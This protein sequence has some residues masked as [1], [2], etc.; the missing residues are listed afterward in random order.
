MVSA[1]ANQKEH[2]F[3]TVHEEEGTE[4]VLKFLTQRRDTRNQL[5][6]NLVLAS[7]TLSDLDNISAA[8]KDSESRRL[9]PALDAEA[10]CH[11]LENLPV[12]LPVSPAGVTSP[13]VLTKAALTFLEPKLEI[14]DAGS[15]KQP[16]VMHRRINDEVAKYPTQSDLGRA[17][18]RKLVTDLFEQG[19]NDSRN[20][21][22]LELIAECVP[23]GTTSAALVLAL[24][25]L[26]SDSSIRMPPEKLASYCSSS[27]LGAKSQKISFI[28]DQL[29]FL[30]TSRG[31]ALPE[32]VSQCLRDP[33]EAISL[34]GDTMQ[35]Y[36]AGYL[37]G[38]ASKGQTTILAGGSQ[39]IAVYRIASLLRKPVLLATNSLIATTKYVALDKEA[40][41]KDLAAR[42]KAPL[43]S[44]DPHLKNSVHQ[45]LRAYEEG[46]VK[47][48]V[49]AGAACLMAYTLAKISGEELLE[50]IDKTYGSLTGA[51]SPGQ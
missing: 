43:I 6:F 35:A 46:H 32:L 13:V 33:L 42:N 45:G 50:E 29:D 7:T 22:E 24:T 27:L 37:L 11:S 18:D 31:K 20:G 34:A 28:R 51:S 10:L 44:V 2:D 14:V 1:P 21:E 9:T 5:K 12:S 38:R 25:N 26:E 3:L 15:F 4:Q 30:E 19:L 8:G 16:A 23:G 40:K 41:V 48:G 36:A 39:M 17:L 47:E 49:G